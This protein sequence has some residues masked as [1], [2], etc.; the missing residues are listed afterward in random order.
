MQFYEESLS[1]N[2]FLFVRHSLTLSAISAVLAVSIGLFMAYGVRLSRNAGLRAI[3]QFASLGYAVPG[4]VLAVGVMIPMG[5]LDLG[6][7]TLSREL[8]G[9]PTG[10]LLSG[11]IMAITYGY[12]VRFLALSYGTAEASLS[13]VTPNMDGA[14]R[15]LGLGPGKTL[16]RVHFPLVRGSLLAAGVLVFVDGMKELTMTII[17]RPFNYETLATFVHQFASNEQLEESALGAL[18]IV[19][20]G[21]LPII[22][23]SATIRNT[24]PGQPAGQGA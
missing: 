4:A 22:I 12:L 20:S 7:Q 8:W 1:A 9:V 10:L 6:L 5:K 11:T 17:L 23:L 18:A 2:F 21:I 15:T 16:W 24:R 13:K 14:A 3:S 19:A